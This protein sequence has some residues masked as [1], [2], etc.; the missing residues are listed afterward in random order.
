VDAD[1]DAGLLDLLMRRLAHSLEETAPEAR[2]TPELIRGSFGSDAGAIGA[3]S[4]P[5]FFSFSPRA[6]I[7]RSGSKYHEGSNDGQ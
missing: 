7:L 4:L 5:M 1:V 6:E 3:A 2:D